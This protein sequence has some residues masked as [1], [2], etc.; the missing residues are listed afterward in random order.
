MNAFFTQTTTYM[1]MYVFSSDI[2][3][4]QVIV[5]DIDVNTKDGRCTFPIHQARTSASLCKILVA[6]I[7]CGTEVQ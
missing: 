5:E 7:S 1:L 4:N 3:S 2:Q 6:L